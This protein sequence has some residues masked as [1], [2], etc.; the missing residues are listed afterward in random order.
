MASLGNNSGR[1]FVFIRFWGKKFF[2]CK[3][4]VTRVTQATQTDHNSTLPEPPISVSI[5]S[6]SEAA[7]TASDNVFQVTRATQTHSDSRFS[8]PE[9]SVSESEPEAAS[10][11]SDDTFLDEIEQL[12]RKYKS[13]GLKGKAAQVLGRIDGFVNGPLDE[14]DGP[15]QTPVKNSGIGLLTP[16]SSPEEELCLSSLEASST[17]I[18]DGEIR[19]AL[20]E[21]LSWDPEY[22]KYS[23]YKLAD[24]MKAFGYT[25]YEWSVAR[26]KTLYGRL[27][28]LDICTPGDM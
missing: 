6:E 12:I 3:R 7:S 2:N 18:G 24:F 8:E 19:S 4:Q 13:I 16:P 21:D 26:V 9:N 17:A 22:A 1:L 11:L 14:P 27:I 23:R 20:E 25:E 5:K 10:S 15:P 28:F